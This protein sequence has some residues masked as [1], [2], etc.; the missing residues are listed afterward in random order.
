LRIA[1]SCL[2]ALGDNPDRISGDAERTSKALHEYAVKELPSHLKELASAD[3][4]GADRTRKEELGTHLYSLL[5]K[6]AYLKTWLSAEYATDVRNVWLDDDSTELNILSL[7]KN[8]DVRRPVVDKAGGVKVLETDTVGVYCKA[9]AFLIRQWL[10]VE[11][12][13]V[14]SA[15]E[16]VKAH[17]LKVCKPIF[18]PVLLVLTPF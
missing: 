14:A 4:T 17:Y 10:G 5:L 11:D 13:D 7:F 16:W 9:T 6:E 8:E 12:W 3:L 15:F 2:K 18:K 1:V